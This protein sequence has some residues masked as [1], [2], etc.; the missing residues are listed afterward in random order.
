MQSP[1]ISPSHRLQTAAASWGLEATVHLLLLMLHTCSQLDPAELPPNLLLLP[2]QSQLHSVH[3]C[4]IPHRHIRLFLS[5]PLQ[6][7][8]FAPRLLPRPAAM[9]CLL[10]HFVDYVLQL[11]HHL[12]HVPLTVL[13]LQFRSAFASAN[14]SSIS[15]VLFTDRGVDVKT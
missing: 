5:H 9:W 1:V 8:Q 11:P 14:S 4:L 2:V 12:V 6:C 3:V 13:P 15:A 10:N 7:L